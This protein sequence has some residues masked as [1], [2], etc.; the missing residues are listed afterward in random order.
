MPDALNPTADAQY[1]ATQQRRADVQTLQEFFATADASS[2]QDK[3]AALTSNG[4]DAGTYA[5]KKLAIGY[6]LTDDDRKAVEAQRQEIEGKAPEIQ[7]E[8]I[9]HDPISVAIT[10]MVGAKPL[11]E[12]GESALSLLPG[13]IQKTAGTAA[14]QAAVTKISDAAKEMFPNHPN[15]AG[16][17]G[18]LAGAALLGGTAKIGAP[19]AETPSEPSQ[20]GIEPEG[21]ETPENAPAPEPAQESEAPEDVS[22]ETSEPQAAGETLAAPEPHSDLAALQNAQ[23]NPMTR[24]EMTGIQLEGEEGHQLPSTPLS[25]SDLVRAQTYTGQVASNVVSAQRRFLL[26][27]ADEDKQALDAAKEELDAITPQMKAIWHQAGLTLQKV[28]ATDPSSAQIRGAFNAIEQNQGAPERMAMALS[29]LPTSAEREKMLSDAAGMTD[30]TAKG[31]LYKLYVNSILSLNSVAKKAVSDAA[32]IVFQIPA[33]GLAEA[34]SRMWE[35]GTGQDYGSVGVAPGETQAVVRGMM[36]NWSDSLKLGLDSAREGKPMFEGDVGFFDQPNAQADNIMTNSGFENTWWGRAIDYYGHL[37]SVPG[38]A[39]IGTDQFSKSMQYSMELN[40]LATRQGYIEAQAQ[41][42]EGS[43]LS[44]KAQELA[45]GYLEETPGWMSDQAMQTAKVNTFQED[46]QGSL[47]KLDAF[48][49]SSYLTRTLM[50]FF[51][52]P[53]NITLQGIRQS[54][55]APTSGVW[56]DTVVG[57][58]P[59]AAIAL[60]KTALGSAVMAYF[61]Y[62]VLKGNITG[63]VPAN[64]KGTAREDWLADHDRYSIRSGSPDDQRWTSYG[65]LEPISW[66]LGLAADS[67][68]MFSYL[69]EG[70]VEHATGVLARAA[71]NEMGRQ[72]MWGALHMVVNALDDVERG[73]TTSLGQVGSRMAAGLIPSNVANLAGGIDPVRRQTE[74]LMS[75]LRN[76]IPWLKEGGLPTLDS[77][78]R[79]STVPPGFMWNEFPAYVSTRMKQADPVVDEMVRLNGSIGFEPPQV[80][81]SIGGPAD[82]DN[83]DSPEGS[84]YGATLTPAERNQW[85]E[86]RGN[87]PNPDDGRKLYD[88]VSH[89]MQSDQYQES[90]DARRADELHKLFTGY[91]HMAQGRMLAENDD[92]RGRVMAAFASKVHARTEGRTAAIT[93]P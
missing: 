60:S 84:V 43:E 91:Q 78:G 24:E 2:P 15:V 69:E 44:A 46:L 66:L 55:L 68:P 47:A 77:F 25:Y 83:L 63:D 61:T 92:L 14:A 85:L 33:R 39:I 72:P 13:A 26:T 10:S 30:W 79:P 89:L 35:V 6:P 28:G 76:R 54:P 34:G 17:I 11:M 18:T 58:G 74:D 29:N 93:A 88:A 87:T 49:Q 64:L 38:R 82:A 12:G 36:E 37:V 65:G 1:V 75:T 9:A 53:V 31:A 27:G 56:R 5:Q 50:P 90:S 16:L 19:G 70:D 21:A 22:R 67:A 20:P 52:T 4:L 62:H 81:K 59:E 45:Q 73:K 80:P 86:A 8:D 23:A 40:A 42:L 51:K 71:V 41:G 3:S 7:A 48:R 57:G 32:N